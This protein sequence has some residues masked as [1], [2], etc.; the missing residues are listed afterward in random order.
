MIFVVGDRVT[1]EYVDGSGNKTFRSGEIKNFA[2]DGGG[3][4]SYQVDL[5]GVAIW[6]LES[7]LTRE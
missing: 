3:I 7:E 4:V 6:K 1:M 5:G 2:I